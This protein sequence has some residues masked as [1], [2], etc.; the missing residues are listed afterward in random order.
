MSESGYKAEIVEL[1]MRHGLNHAQATSRTAEKVVDLLMSDERKA[2]NDAADRQLE[3]ARRQIA[4]I[5]KYSDVVTH[6]TDERAVNAIA[7]F[8]AIITIAETHGIANH[9]AAQEAGYIVYA[10][11]SKKPSDSGDGYEPPEGACAI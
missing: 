3:T 6:L 2:L 7:L 4:D 9:T 10:Y 8:N 11:L 1:L 5:Q